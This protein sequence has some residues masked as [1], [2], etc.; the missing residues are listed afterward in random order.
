[1]KPYPV[2][3]RHRIVEAVDQHLGTIEEIAPFS[4]C[5]PPTSTNCSAD[6]ANGTT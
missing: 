6:A 1:M 4:R 5:M 2:E 3:L